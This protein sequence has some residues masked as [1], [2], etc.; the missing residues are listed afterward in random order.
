MSPE[1]TKNAIVIGLSS[2]GI[3]EGETL[4]V[5]SSLESLGPIDGGAETVVS[6]FLHL[7]GPSGTLLM[8][9]LSYLQEPHHLHDTRK[10]ACCVGA[11]PEYFRKRPGTL[12]SLHPTHS[13]CGFGKDAEELFAEHFL[14]STPCGEHS[15]FRKISERPA[16]IVMLGCGLRPNTTMHAIEELL[17]PPYLLKKEEFEYLITDENGLEHSKKYFRHDFAGWEQ[18][19]ERIAELPGS[20]SFIRRGRVLEAE[21]FV[22]DAQKLRAAVLSKMLED[23]LFFVLKK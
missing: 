6:S 7:L 16:K 9:G 20:G 13:M 4:L 12:R 18:H 8:P 5:H 17:R 2:L 14:D 10:T 11:L 15:P 3:G 22:L 1:A 23:E 21:I 19:Y